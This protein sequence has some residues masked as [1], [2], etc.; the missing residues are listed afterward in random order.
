MNKNRLNKSTNAI[1]DISIDKNNKSRNILS[2]K[3]K[4]GV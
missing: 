3:N 4:K 2:Y 1:K